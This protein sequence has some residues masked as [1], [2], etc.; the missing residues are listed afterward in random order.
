LKILDTEYAIEEYA[1]IVS[2]D[3]TE[4][5]NKVNTALQELIDDGT[6]AKIVAKYIPAE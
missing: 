6:V 4:L 3:N 2:K 1:A 5:F